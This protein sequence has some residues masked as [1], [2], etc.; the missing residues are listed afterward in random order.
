MLTQVSKKELRASLRILRALL[1]WLAKYPKRNWESAILRI[2]RSTVCQ[3]S[4]KELRAVSG[5]ANQ[6]GLIPASIQKGIESRD[7]GERGC[8]GARAS[9][10]KGIE[11]T[12]AFLLTLMLA[13]FK[14]PK[15]NWESTFFWRLWANLIAKYPKRNWELYSLHCLDSSGLLKYPKRNWE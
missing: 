11:S 13:D 3:V 12:K 14:Y 1:A 10:Q 2:T 8:D 4:K 5:T 7:R 15:R 6:A 9:I